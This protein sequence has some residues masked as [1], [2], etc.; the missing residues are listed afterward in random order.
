VEE[1]T[2]LEISTPFISASLTGATLYS[3]KGYRAMLGG[4]AVGGGAVVASYVAYQAVGI[5][6]GSLGILFL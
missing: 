2:G 1:K 5:P 6:Y 4:A 3:R